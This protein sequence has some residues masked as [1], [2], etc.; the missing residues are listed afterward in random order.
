MID[1]EIA[2]PLIEWA[3]NTDA[4]AAL[5]L[6]GSRAKGMARPS[7]DHDLAIE[8]RPMVK[9]HDWAFGDYI[10]EGDNWKARLRNIVRGDVSLVAFRDDLPG[11]FD[12]RVDGV[13]LW[14]RPPAGE[15]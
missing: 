10:S 15:R 12:P 9:D 2:R 13:C 3:A 1:D 14:K 5:W 4:V 6:F 7:S 11:K 8:L